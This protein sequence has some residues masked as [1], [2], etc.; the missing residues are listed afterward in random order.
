MLGGLGPM[1]LTIIFLIV[2]L[3]FGGRKIPEIAKG[4]GKGI[5]EF[6]T[7]QKEDPDKLANTSD[8]SDAMEPKAKPGDNQ[9]KEDSASS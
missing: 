7:A 4:L 6:K 5:K 2:L 8:A 9:K 1:E 3:I